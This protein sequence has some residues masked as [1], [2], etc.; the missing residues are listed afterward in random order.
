MPEKPLYKRSLETIN[1]P[2]ERFREAAKGWGRA[3]QGL[4]TTLPSQSQQHLP[5]PEEPTS[6]IG[7]ISQGEEIQTQVRSVSQ[8]LVKGVFEETLPPHQQE[9]LADFGSKPVKKVE[10]VT[11]EGDTA[12]YERLV[13]DKDYR[14]SGPPDFDNNYATMP[15]DQLKRQLL[16]WYLQFTPASLRTD[17]HD[18][19]WSRRIDNLRATDPAPLRFFMA[20]IKPNI[21]AGKKYNLP[22]WD[23]LRLWMDRRETHPSKRGNETLF[24]TLK[25]MFEQW[26]WVIDQIEMKRKNSTPLENGMMVWELW[27]PKDGELKRDIKKRRIVL[28]AA[29]RHK[30]LKDRE[31]D[32]WNSM[33]KLTLAEQKTAEGQQKEPSIDEVARKRAKSQEQSEKEDRKGS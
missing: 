26:D 16:Q 23:I 17:K 19:E 2:S 14:V 30:D 13:L 24:A 31:L 18:K 6:H 32:N 27:G 10:K 9:K 3:D 21:I 5:H 33:W 12:A 11:T 7:L 4:R 28:E 8:D 22:R 29:E 1:L 25:G 20:Y 15:I